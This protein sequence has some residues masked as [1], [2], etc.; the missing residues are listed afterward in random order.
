MIEIVPASSKDHLNE[1]EELFREYADWLDLEMCYRNIDKEIAEL[2]GAYGPPG[3]NLLLAYVDGETAG[4]AGVR[5]WKGDVC[6]MKRL[7]V[8]PRFR[9]TGIGR[10]LAEMIIEEARRIGYR[11]MRLD[12]LPQMN[13]A[14]ELYKSLGFKQ[15]EKYRTSPTDDSQYF[16]LA[17]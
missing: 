11:L 5:K 15:I 4:C 13:E 9:G 3:G 17:L 2:P 6:E 10:K 14:I 12:T 8:R 16:E 7:Y 1:A